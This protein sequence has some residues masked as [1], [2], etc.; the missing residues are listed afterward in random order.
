[1]GIN[2]ATEYRISSKKSLELNQVVGFFSLKNLRSFIL[3]SDS[4]RFPTL[5]VLCNLQFLIL[6]SVCVGGL[7]ASASCVILWNWLEFALK[8]NLR[9]LDFAHNL[10]LSQFKEVD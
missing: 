4:H 9:G 3:R 2:T 6:L 8:D 7:P 1:M 10:F 5:M